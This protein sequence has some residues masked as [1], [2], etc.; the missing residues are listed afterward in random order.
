MFLDGS[1][2]V[3]RLVVAA[4]SKFLKQLLVE[5]QDDDEP[6]VLLP[7]VQLV[8]LAAL[9]DFLYTVTFGNS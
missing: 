7:D 9:M 8:V 1:V 5:S 3:H 6:V 2:R 4:A